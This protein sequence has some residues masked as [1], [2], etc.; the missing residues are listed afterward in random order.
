MKQPKPIYQT[1]YSIPAVNDR[2]LLMR[3]SGTYVILGKVI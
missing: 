2:V 3:V 1:N